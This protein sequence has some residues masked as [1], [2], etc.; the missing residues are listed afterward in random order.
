M[1][2]IR[3]RYVDC[4]FLDAGYCGA[5]AVEFDPEVGCMTFTH[6]ADAMEDE[7]WNAEDLDEV[8]E[9]EEPF[10]TEDDLDDQWM[11][12]EEEK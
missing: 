11:E 6:V 2:R 9:E 8:W 5:S 7:E 3:C 1:P 10:E 12:E 4:V